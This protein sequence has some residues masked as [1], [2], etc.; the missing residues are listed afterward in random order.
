MH[1]SVRRCN[2]VQNFLSNV[3]QALITIHMHRCTECLNSEGIVQGTDI[4]P[5]YSARY[6]SARGSITYKFQC[7]MKFG[8]HM[9][10][11]IAEVNKIWRTK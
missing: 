2:L 4:R 9:L 1:I 11:R 7:T 6:I 8:E 10:F 3:C 5:N